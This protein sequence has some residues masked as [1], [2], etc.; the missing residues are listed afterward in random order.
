MLKEVFWVGSARKAV[1]SFPEEVRAVFGYAIY[2]AQL[3]EKHL[4]AIPLK[5]FSGAGV[6]EVVEDF[7][8]DAY[9]CVYTIRYGDR[10][11]VLHAFQK[12]SKRGIATP[13]LEMDVVESRLRE[14]RRI[15]EVKG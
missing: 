7:Q 8:T 9:R 12:K 6:L 13:R 2:L 11:Y 3:G 10:V 1:K 14:V 5:G 15:E 4:R